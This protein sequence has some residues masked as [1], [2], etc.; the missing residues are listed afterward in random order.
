MGNFFLN[1]FTQ[2]VHIQNDQC[3]MGII[4]RYVCWGTHQPPPGSPAAAPRPPEPQGLGQP[5]GVPPPPY[6]PQNCRTPLGVTHWLVAAP[7]QPAWTKAGRWE[8][9]R[10]PLQQW[11]PR[12]R[13]MHCGRATYP[14]K[15]CLASPVITGADRHPLHMLRQTYRPTAFR[16]GHLYCVQRQALEL[17]C[18][19]SVLF[20]PVRIVVYLA[21]P[22]TLT[23]LCPREPR[24]NPRNEPH[25]PEYPPPA[26]FC[27]IE[28][29]RRRLELDLRGFWG[30]LRTLRCSPTS[31]RLSRK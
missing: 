4:L 27:V 20:L 2:L 16:T 3:V 13:A 26:E 21:I 24:R 10:G 6:S 25:A 8:G 1:F 31:S 23:E 7:V 30:A 22:A 29:N 18:T 17:F 15:L 12:R 28:G 19:P 5:R 11:E 9:T 14:T